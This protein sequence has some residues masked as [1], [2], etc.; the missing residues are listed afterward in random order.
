[1]NLPQMVPT[2]FNGRQATRASGLYIGAICP[3]NHN[4]GK[5]LNHKLEKS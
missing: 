1:M 4:V 3:L 2:L 5:F